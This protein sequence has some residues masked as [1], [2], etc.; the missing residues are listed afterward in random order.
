MGNSGIWIAASQRLTPYV[1][2]RLIW[3][4]GESI[5]KPLSGFRSGNRWRWLVAVA[6]ATAIVLTLLQSSTTTAA[7]VA[8]VIAGGDFGGADLTPT[9]GDKLSGTFTN[10]GT[11][12]IAAGDTVLVDPGV[13]LSIQASLIDING[14]LD[15]SGAGAAGGASVPNIPSCADTGAI[16]GDPGSG[17]GGGGGGRFGCNTHGSGGGGGGYGGAGGVSASIFNAT[18]LTNSGAASGGS[19]VGDA[20]SPSIKFGSGGGSGS[21]Y[22]QSDLSG[23]SGAGG[24]GGASISLFGKVVLTGTILADGAGGT[25]PINQNG[26]GGGGGSGGGVLLDGVLSLRG[27]ISAAGGAGVTNTF[28]FFSSGGGGGGGRIKLFGCSFGGQSLTS[29]VSGGGFGLSLLL[30][31]TEA[32]AGG[33]GTIHDGT[34]G[35]CKRVFPVAILTTDEFDATTVDHTTVTFAGASETHVDKKTGEARRHEEDV[36]GDGDTDLVFHFRL[37]DTGLTCES[38][39][40][41]LTGETFDGQAIDGTDAVCMVGG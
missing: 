28:G 37:G 23:S 14:T 17:P 30:G 25:L 6:A 21:S 40:G 5:V 29:D 36:D 33:D 8:A 12:S 9:D 10:V 15:G 22:N 26:A 4:K 1:A 41:T 16:T 32:T 20:T 27:A 11:F 24:A 31:G 34:A 3:A 39:D 19:M 38:A 13:P 7:P 2:T 35:P 18:N